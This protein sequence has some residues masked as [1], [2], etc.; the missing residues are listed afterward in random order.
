[1]RFDPPFAVGR[2]NRRYKR[3]LAD[4]E[5]NRGDRLTV[6]CPNTGAMLGCDLPGSEAWYSESENPKRKYR[7]TL[8]VVVTDRG[9]I[10]VNTSRANA[11]VREAL[12]SGVTT[13]F[14][15]FQFERNE[16]PI[17]DEAG[18]FDLLLRDDA[19]QRAC[20]VEVKNMTLCDPDGRGSFPDAV[21]ERALKHVTALERC[22]A[23]GDRGVLVFCVQHT[24]ILRATIADE[25]DPAYGRAVRTAADAGVEVI[26]YKCRIERDEISIERPIPVDLSDQCTRFR[27]LTSVS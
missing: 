5:T 23:A 17:P 7:H 25:I 26:A 4:L 19:A 18:R 14:S 3:F 2:L 6:H 11:L 10:G 12:E 20:F 22:V 1:V 13:E 21:S 27:K 15:G 8:E 24:G 16:V 9:R